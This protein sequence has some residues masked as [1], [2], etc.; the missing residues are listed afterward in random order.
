MLR[1][2]KGM[3]ARAADAACKPLRVLFIG[4]SA[5]QRNNIPRLLC[6]LA[7]RAGYCIEAD[8][9][10]KGGAT[11]AEYADPNGDRGREAMRTIAQGNYDLVFLQEHSKCIAS[12]EWREMTASASKSLDEAIRKSGARTC[13]YVRPPTGKAFSGYDSYSQCLEYDKLFSGIAAELGAESVYVNRAFAYAIK[14]LTVS[15]WALDNAH[16]GVEGA[17]LVACVFFAT[18]FDTS[19]TVLDGNGLPADVAFSLQ[20][21]ADLVASGRF[22][23][24]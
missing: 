5:T 4:N 21:A 23:L 11:L 20:Q 2:S 3:E 10:I 22:V 13:F 14:H 17:Y 19:A 1:D 18:V 9:V 15:L 12:Q 7:N 16:T 8:A 24:P 6:D